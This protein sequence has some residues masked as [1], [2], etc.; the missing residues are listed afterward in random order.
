MATREV[1]KEFARILADHLESSPFAKGD[2]RWLYVQRLIRRFDFVPEFWRKCPATTRVWKGGAWAYVSLAELEEVELIRVMLGPPVKEYMD[3]RMAVQYPDYRPWLKRMDPKD[4]I[5]VITGRDVNGIADLARKA[6]FQ[7]RRPTKIDVPFYDCM[8][9]DWKTVADARLLPGV[10]A[11]TPV[12]VANLNALGED[13]F[14]VRL[15]K[16]YDN[17][18]EHVVLNGKHALTRWYLKVARACERG[19]FGLDNK[20]LSRLADAIERPIRYGGDLGALEEYLARWRISS[21]LRSLPPP[22]VGLEHLRG[23]SGIVAK[24]KSS[25]SMS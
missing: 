1:N 3:A 9:I 4:Q 25:S 19:S 13:V 12:T 10:S 14:S 2:D 7:G 15:H 11:T 21:G 16:A 6:I 18:Y 17:V 22:A 8:V 20:Q 5:S 23:F 24:L